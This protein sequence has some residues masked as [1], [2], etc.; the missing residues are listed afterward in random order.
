VDQNTLELY[1]L[2]Y[3]EECF[4]HLGYNG[5]MGIVSQKIE[6]FIT[7]TVTT[8]KFTILRKFILQVLFEISAGFRRGFQNLN[9]INML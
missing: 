4:Y 2:D 7:T 3:F 5:D 9:Y 6:F 8:P 1:K